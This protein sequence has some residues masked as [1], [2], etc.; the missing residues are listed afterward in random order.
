MA[1]SV[2]APSV[3]ERLRAKGAGVVY[4]ERVTFEAGYVSTATFWCLVTADPVG[5]DDGFVHPHVCVSSRPC[6]CVAVPGDNVT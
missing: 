4:G 3:C 1:T 2:N 6:F 5:P